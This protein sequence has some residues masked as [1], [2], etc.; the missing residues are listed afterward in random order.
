MLNL[1]EHTSI[2]TLAT[3]LLCCDYSESCH[4]WHKLLMSFSS[5]EDVCICRRISD[6][7]SF[8]FIWRAPHSSKC[9]RIVSHTNCPWQTAHMNVTEPLTQPYISPTNKT[10]VMHWYTQIIGLKY[11]RFRWNVWG[12]AQLIICL[13]LICLWSERRPC[14]ESPDSTKV[15]LLE[16]ASLN[17]SKK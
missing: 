13:S 6:L 14:S 11:W 7:C 15:L 4:C 8:L 5:M 1:P 3:E 16:E 9:N 12:T 17:G 10:S 2:L